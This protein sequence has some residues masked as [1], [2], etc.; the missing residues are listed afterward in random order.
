MSEPIFVDSPSE[1]ISLN[2]MLK[3]SGL[4]FVQGILEGKYSAP[5]I[6]KTLNFWLHSAEKGRVVFRGAPQYSS[7]NPMGGVHGGWYGTLL[8]STMSC[9][10][11]TMQPAGSGYTTLEF[12]T[13][14]TRAIPVGMEI[15]A[16]GTIQH[17]GRS[18]GVAEGIIRGV[19]DGKTYATGLATCLV[20]KP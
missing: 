10:V 8:D 6:S 2:E 20:L 15:E 17:S 3:I 16:I 5:P 13:N 12:K 11:Q 9:A 1:L 19:E 7:L 4:E 18:T 14:I